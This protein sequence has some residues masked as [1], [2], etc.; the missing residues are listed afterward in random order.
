MKN[1]K[2]ILFASINIALAA[3]LNTKIKVTSEEYVLIGSTFHLMSSRPPGVCVIQPGEVCD[4]IKI[5][6]SG[7]NVDPSNFVPNTINAKWEEE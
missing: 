2:L 1:F 5:N 6:P 3:A 4:Y 7:S